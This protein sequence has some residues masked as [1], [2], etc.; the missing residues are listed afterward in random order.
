MSGFLDPKAPSIKAEY[1]RYL[2]GD[3]LGKLI[4]KNFLL[5]RLGYRNEQIDMPL[6]RHGDATSKYANKGKLIANLNDGSVATRQGT[7]RLEI[8]CARINIANRYLG[9]TKHNWAFKGMLTSPSKKK[10]MKYDVLIAIG[11][12]TLG[13]EDADY[14][15][16]L[17]SLQAQFQKDGRKLSIEALPHDK[18]FLSLCSFFVIPKCEISTN[19]I[20]LSIEAIPNSQYAP[21]HAEGDDTVGCKRIWSKALRTIRER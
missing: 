6:A 15:K 12:R 3:L 21:Y 10:R 11:L 20:R 1:S 2:D 13:L 9:R 18:R 8:K 7:I 14:W 17:R 16:H 5:N 4:A 19:Q